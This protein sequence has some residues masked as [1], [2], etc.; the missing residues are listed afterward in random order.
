MDDIIKAVANNM[1]RFNKYLLEGHVQESV[2]R[3]PDFLE[4]TLKQ[5][6]L[7]FAGHLTYLGYYALSPAERIK[8]EFG[9]KDPKVSVLANEQQ[10]Y[11]YQFRVESTGT[12][13]PVYVYLPYLKDRM[14][15]IN[16]NK[17]G[18]RRGIVESV[19]NS[20]PNGITAR[21]IRGPMHFTRR[22]DQFR[23][24]SAVTNEY[25]TESIIEAQVYLKSGAAKK[26][27][28]TTIVHYFL[29]KF[30]FGGTIGMFGLSTNDI[31]FVDEITGSDTGVYEYYH[32]NNRKQ[33]NI[34][35]FLKVK[36]SLLE[37]S[38]IRKLVANILY[39]ATYFARHTAEELLDPQAIRWRVM[40]GAIL[41][42]D[43]LVEAQAKNQ[44]DSHI[45]SL[46]KYL[47]PDTKQRLHEKG[48]TVN[49]VY[50]M[51]LYI[52]NQ[53]DWIL[54]NTTPQNL[55]HK[56]IDVMTGIL[57]KAIVTPVFKRFYRAQQ[58]VKKVDDRESRRTIL[59]LSPHMMRGINTS[60]N[61]IPQPAVYNG[62]WLMAVGVAKTRDNGTAKSQQDPGM[63]FHPSNA[64]VESIVAFSGQSPGITGSI[65]P[66]LQIDSSGNIIKPNYAE[67]IERLHQYLPFK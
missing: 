56:K 31:T 39:V 42:P 17:Y 11:A 41:H 2:D 45:D 38:V 28:S 1:P 32:A 44:I 6:A 34:K 64:W 59:K 60:P 4:M 35:V 18:L 33:T 12:I 53:L 16:G 67:D 21:V 8:Y 57:V 24:T 58:R 48:I 22:K 52:F 7:L 51:F 62:N 23:M 15:V 63:R 14:L 13:I 3:I 26:A 43:I 36:K 30:G 37:N 61:V 25:Y 5:A 66:F 19:F 65:N 46:D 29:C 54:T 40:M 9:T 49:S 20:I 47:D 50:D 10:L 27:I 55:E